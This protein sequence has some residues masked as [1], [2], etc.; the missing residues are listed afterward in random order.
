[1]K[2]VNNTAQHDSIQ[3]HKKYVTYGSWGKK[4]EEGTNTLRHA[5]TKATIFQLKPSLMFRDNLATVP[6]AQPTD[7]Q[8]NNLQLELTPRAKDSHNVKGFFVAF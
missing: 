2:V 7:S 3:R 1:L 4:G 6:S 8:Q 5:A